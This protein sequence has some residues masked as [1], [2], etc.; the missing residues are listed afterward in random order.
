MFNDIFKKKKLSKDGSIN[1]TDEIINTQTHMI[2][3]I[4]SLFG[5]VVLIVKSSIA[6]KPWHI[7]S[8]SIYGASLLL[9]FLASTLHHGVNSSP[10]IEFI[11]KL[12]DY[13]AIFPL[14]AGTYT[15]LCLILLKNWLGWS[16]F[17]VVWALA[18]I[19]I[20]IKAIYPD[21]PRWFSSTI[22]ITMGWVGTVIAIP[23]FKYLKLS[24]I[25]L[26]VLGGIFY[27]AGFIIYNIEKPNPIK[28][29][30]GFHEIWHI[31]VMLGALSHYLMM[32][33]IVLPY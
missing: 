1:V 28:G 13:F 33:F 30:F 16:V 9:V 22:Y 8:F 14:I 10:K 12:F 26:L 6:S 18:V 19:G 2:G 23:L 17:G 27:S 21:I 7:V 4:F 5:L 29:K 25:V 24:G 32:Y 31:L 3:A 11:F 20:V 15:P